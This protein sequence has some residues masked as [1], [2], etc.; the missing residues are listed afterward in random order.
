MHRGSSP[1][2]NPAEGRHWRDTDSKVLYIWRAGRGWVAEQF[3][4]PA[5]GRRAD[6]AADLGIMPPEPPP[7]QP[8]AP[9]PRAAE[10][11]PVDQPQAE[12][13]AQAEEMMDAGA[14]FHHGGEVA[15]DAPAPEIVKPD[16]VI[17]RFLVAQP[18]AP[19]PRAREVQPEPEGPKV[20]APHERE[21]P[22]PILERHARQKPEDPLAKVR[23]REPASP[24]AF[25][26]EFEAQ[27]ARVRAGAGIVEIR[28]ISRPVDEA[29]GGASS[30]N[31]I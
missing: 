28:P 12:R 18:P 3:D 6:E 30:L 4:R 23:K 19:K 21:A 20:S 24:P 31:F 9:K 29:V 14:E 22:H 26:P 7:L 13:I 1:P 10:P 5:I 27:M 8:P 2:K 15:A 25:S 11:E 17:P 16:Q